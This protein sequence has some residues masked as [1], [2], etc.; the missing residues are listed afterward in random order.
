MNDNII[1]ALLTARMVRSY[2]DFDGHEATTSADQPSIQAALQS[3]G[4]AGLWSLLQQQGYAYLADEVG[5]GKT[6]QAMGV[7]AT[8]FL[9][10]PDSRVVIVCASVSLQEQWQKEWSAFLG[11][12]YRLL[13]DRLLSADAVQLQELRLHQNLRQFTAALKNDDSRIHLL[14]YSSFSRPLSLEKHTVRGMLSDYAA[15][16]GVADVARLNAEELAIAVKFEA[17]PAGWQDDM[18]RALAAQ[19]CRRLAALLTDGR[20]ALAQPLSPL[21]LVVFDEAQYLRHTD[22]WQNQHI[23]HIFHSNAQ[24]WLFLSATPLHSGARDIHSL[25]AYLAQQPVAAAKT[26]ANEAWD[27]VNLL[28]EMMIRRTRAYA[29]QRGERYGKIE[30]RRYDRVRYSGADDPFMA[31]SMALVQKRLVGALAGR[32][33]RFRLGECAS[34]ESLSSSV[35][36]SV[37][38]APVKAADAARP[39]LEPLKDRKQ[40]EPAGQ[41][42]DRNVIDELNHSFVQ[43]MAQPGGYGLPHA[44]LN[45]MVDALFDHSIA[46]GSTR[47]TLVFVR[48]IDTVEEIRDLLHVRF[49]QEVDARLTGWH[50]LL[51]LPGVQGEPWQGSFWLVPATG[52]EAL[53]PLPE[54][55]VAANDD[56]EDDD[57]ELPPAGAATHNQAYRQQADL[58]YF[59]ALKQRSETHAHNGKLV[60]FRS[61]LHSHAD[62]LSKPMRGFLHR[63]PAPQDGESTVQDDAAWQRNRARWERLLRAV[64]EREYLA[65]PSQQWLFADPALDAP[66]SF[67]LAALQLCLLQSLR[68]T[69]FVVDLFVLHTHLRQA[70]DGASELPDKL[71]WLLEQ[72]A[73]QLPAA[74]AQYVANQRARLRD[75]I[76]QFDLIV[77]KCFRSGVVASWEE[78][79]RTR[80]GAVFRPLAPVIGRS[81]RVRNRHAIAH[82]NLPCHP[83]VLVC[84]DVLK[85]GVDMHLF[86]DRVEHYGVAWTSGDLEQRIGRIDRFGSLISRRIG[87]HASQHTGL[88]RLQ[89]GFPYLEGTLDQHQVERV[90]RAKIASDLRMDL[91]KRK[92]EIGEISIAA[93]DAWEA[94]SA[95]AGTVPQDGAV[96]FPHS[97]LAVRHGGGDLVLPPGMVY[98]R[99]QLEV[100]AGKPASADSADSFT[101]LPAYGASVVRRRQ[102]EQHGLLRRAVDVHGNSRWAEEFVMVR[103]A[104][105]APSPAS[106]LREGGPYAVQQPPGVGFAFDPGRNT[107]VW[108]AG[109]APVLLEAIGTAFWLVRCYV[110]AD[111][112]VDLG[113][114]RAPASWLAEHNRGRSAGYL[115]EADGAVWFGAM[116][117][118]T[119][120]ADRLLDQMAARVHRIAQHL[121]QPGNALDHN[122]YR[123][124]TAFPAGVQSLW[125]KTMK[126]SDVLACGHALNGVQAWFEEAFEAML[127]SLYGDVSV[128]ERALETKRLTFQPD[129]TL[130]LTTS[131]AERFRLQAGLDL[132][133]RLDA[134]FAGPKMWWEVVVTPY[135]KGQ[136]PN[137]PGSE[138]DQLP[139]AAPD[140]WEGDSRSGA[141]AFTSSDERS[142]RYAVVYHAPQDWERARGKLL[143]ALTTVRSKLHELENFTKKHNRDLLLNAL[144]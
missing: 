138:L 45:R 106:L 50:G 56:Q 36:R 21:D 72:P 16:I 84:T 46:N 74:L 8:Q 107:C 114:K 82:F 126:Q 69:D 29:D 94:A 12:C 32:A 6:R 134:P 102:L 115:F 118:R 38:A 20:D 40:S 88:P 30:Y 18:R 75:W 87:A 109:R 99:E 117:L 130:H 67:K 125:M 139:H 62:L 60:S 23:Q 35:S 42:L 53:P 111:S 19:Y 141:A 108:R 2:I 68:Q 128:D 55:P 64:L 76:E 81:G 57:D 93:L 133:G 71:L 43:A 90:I 58:P 91:G 3:E 132:A 54:E 79:W 127:A 5:M 44:K 37:G 103:G 121:R 13:D 98:K 95:P 100:T 124:R 33:N 34:F 143:D 142:Y 120:D 25:D 70:P 105:A 48:R 22:N 4:V 112:T 65:Q 119:P 104:S 15:T 116:V 1:P 63:R 59:E 137:L 41:A 66:L 10:K 123:A 49:Q 31:M 96:Y 86:C 136:V 61:R 51:S 135:A 9:S 89:V 52:A 73:S 110:Q 17:L 47:K 122:R 113:G 7:M 85:E 11:N 101:P 83:N 27:V 80:I 77:G 24:K 97:V 144:G 129:G 26:A 78:V 131:G 140:L 14:R 28:Q 92:D 39:E